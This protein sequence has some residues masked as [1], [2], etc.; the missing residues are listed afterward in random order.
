ME[1][2][3]KLE[4]DL[5]NK[6]MVEKVNGLLSRLGLPIQVDCEAERKQ[7]KEIFSRYGGSEGLAK[8]AL[9]ELSFRIDE[10]KIKEFVGYVSS[11]CAD[12]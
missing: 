1:G 2:L 3:N 8:Y 9:Q 6:S 5:N 7:E 12:Y 11:Y 4:L 10:D